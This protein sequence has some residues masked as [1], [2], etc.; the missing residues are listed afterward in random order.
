M[1]WIRIRRDPKLLKA[2]D[3][4]LGVIDP[5]PAPELDMDLYKIIYTKIHTLK[6]H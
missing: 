2:P 4:E 6:I 1:L 5:D 3:P